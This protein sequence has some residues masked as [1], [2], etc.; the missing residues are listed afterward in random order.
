M[1]CYWW[2]L[3]GLV[4]DCCCYSNKCGHI[5]T[6]IH[7]QSW[8]LVERHQYL[9]I[10]WVVTN[11]LFMCVCV[12]T[13]MC[14]CVCVH[15]CWLWLSCNDG[16]RTSWSILCCQVLTRPFTHA[17]TPP[18]VVTDSE[19]DEQTIPLIWWT[20]RLPWIL[21]VW[22]ISHISSPIA[23]QHMVMWPSYAH[24]ILESSLCKM[25]LRIFCIKKFLSY[26]HFVFNPLA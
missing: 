11:T 14:V 2:S 10:L 26:N 20:Y 12:C 5:C 8:V 17:Y 15:M 18:T 21:V 9:E 6:G 25:C 13:C 24:K 16:S 4:Y 22:V 3:R 1:Y 7:Y 23:L 19:E